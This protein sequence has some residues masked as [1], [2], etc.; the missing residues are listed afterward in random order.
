MSK[1]IST[2]ILVRRDTANNWMNNNPVLR[3][4]EIGFDTTT[5]KHK[6]GDGVSNWRSLPYFVLDSEIDVN[7]T[8]YGILGQDGTITYISAGGS[9]FS[10]TGNVSDLNNDLDFQTKEQVEALIKKALASYGITIADTE[11]TTNKTRVW[12]A[13]ED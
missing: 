5:G 4:G 2:K 13:L 1:T 8:L 10:T 9:G 6:I 7:K 3:A 12:I 11:P